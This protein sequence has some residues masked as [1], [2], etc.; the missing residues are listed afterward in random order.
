MSEK[1]VKE[2]EKAL[3]EGKPLV[4]PVPRDPE[5]RPSKKLDL[6]S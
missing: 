3:R 5:S 4:K 1:E 2:R 6:Y